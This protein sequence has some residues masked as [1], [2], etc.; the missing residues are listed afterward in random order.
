[1]VIVDHVSESLTVLSPLTVS[2]FVSA[3]RN[4]DRPPTPAPASVLAG[5][6]SDLVFQKLSLRDYQLH[7]WG[8]SLP[9]HLKIMER[10]STMIPECFSEVALA[11][12]NQTRPLDNKPLIVLTTPSNASQLAS[13]S[14]NGKQVVV[15]N[16]SHYIMVDRP[17]VVIS[18]IH[19]VVEAVQDHT[20]LKQ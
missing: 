14:S 2:S 9:G 19:E 4:V 5:P 16:S 11:S 6:D 12:R 17:D 1:M 15:A 3:T 13:L 18:A 7:L 20:T 10:N 8:N